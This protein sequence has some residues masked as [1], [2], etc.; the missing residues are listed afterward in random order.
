MPVGV[1]SLYQTWHLLRSIQVGHLEANSTHQS[2]IG[3]RFFLAPDH[4]HF[5]FHRA[6]QSSGISS[7]AVAGITAGCFGAVVLITILL[8][9]LYRNS[10]SGRRRRRLP[11]HSDENYGF[12]D[13]RVD[14]IPMGVTLNPTQTASQFIWSACSIRA[15]NT[16]RHRL[17]SV[18][19]SLNQIHPIDVSRP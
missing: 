15:S 18:H 1:R 9:V 10:R 3:F 5:N 11:V 7:I 2:R 12:Q 4:A 17:G 19:I 14:E 16:L 13:K 8:T 6:I